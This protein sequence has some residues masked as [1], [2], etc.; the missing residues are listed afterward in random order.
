MAYSKFTVA[1][2]EERFGVEIRVVEDL[3]GAYSAVQPSELLRSILHR[4]LPLALPS[5]SEKA[6]SEWIVAPILAEVRELLGERISIHSG[7]EFVVDRKHGLDGFC[8]F[9]I[10]SHFVVATA[11]SNLCAE[12]PRCIATM[13]A[14]RLFNERDG[15]PERVI[16]GCVTT[17]SAWLFLKLADEKTV[18]VDQLEYPIRELDRLVGILVGMLRE[19]HNGL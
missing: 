6:R 1:G 14:A 4:N 8:D 16:Y 2:L 11:E 10:A 5:G 19:A 9:L 7:V 3:V 18:L 17:G 13:I 12:L 15:K